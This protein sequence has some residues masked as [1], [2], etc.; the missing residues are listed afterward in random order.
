M[1]LLKNLWNMELNGCPLEGSLAEMVQN[2]SKT[3]DILGFLKSVLNQLVLFC[4]IAYCRLQ[5][6][7]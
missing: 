5:L 3:S 1:G 2:K 7:S 4:F 6:T